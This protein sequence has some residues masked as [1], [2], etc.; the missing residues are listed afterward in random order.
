MGNPFDPMNIILL[1]FAVVAFIRLRSA[2]GKRTGNEDP[3]NNKTNF[4]FNNFKK[5]KQAKESDTTSLNS[6][7]EI[8]NYLS[9]SDKSF[10]QQSFIEGSKKAYKMVVQNYALGDLSSIRDFISGEVYDGFA[11]AIELRNKLKQKLFNDVIEFDS[12]EIEDATLLKDMVQIQVVFETKMI[13]YGVNSDEEVIE[14]NKDSPQVIK[15]NWIFQKSIR[16]KD[17]GWEL[18]STNADD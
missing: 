1:V 2:L 13:S 14:G 3:L 4:K 7:D 8:L 10:T 11:E 15:D 6:K 9:V 16:S 17:P 12:V 5:L 18:I